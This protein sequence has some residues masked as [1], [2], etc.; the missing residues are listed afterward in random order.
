MDLGRLGQPALAMPPQE[1]LQQRVEEAAVALAPAGVAAASKK[2]N[3][4]NSLCGNRFATLAGEDEEE[5]DVSAEAALK[6]SLYSDVAV[7]KRQQ[8]SELRQDIAMLDAVLH[9][10]RASSSASS[11]EL[12]RTV[13]I[14]L[15]VQLEAEGF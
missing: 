15:L 4:C 11:A 13:A 12:M 6:E 5:E 1:K 14:G 7:A 9:E 10:L 8:A 3:G 2:G